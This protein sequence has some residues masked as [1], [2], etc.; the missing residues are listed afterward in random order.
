MLTGTEFRTCGAKGLYDVVF[1]KALS[2]FVC[3][4]LDG[5]Q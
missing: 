5:P 2:L 3:V 4:W 1:N